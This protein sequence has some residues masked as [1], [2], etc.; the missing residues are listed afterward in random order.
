[1]GCVWPNKGNTRPTRSTVWLQME[2]ERLDV[3]WKLRPFVGFWRRRLRS[4]PSGLR[5]AAGWLR[6]HESS[7]AFNLTNCCPP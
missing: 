2:G 1:M 6:A 3:R 4:L 7:T 5:R